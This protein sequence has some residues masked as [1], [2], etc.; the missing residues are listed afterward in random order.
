MIHLSFRSSGYTIF[1][2]LQWLGPWPG[3][4][5]PGVSVPPGHAPYL[6]QDLD[7]VRMRTPDS[8]LSAKD[9]LAKTRSI[10]ETCPAEHYALSKRQSSDT[11]DYSC[12]AT[13]PC[14][15]GACCAKADAAAMALLPVV[16]ANRQ[17]GCARATVMPMR[18]ADDILHLQ[19][20]SVR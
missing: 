16:M 1:F 8:V 10:V 15:N 17:T 9:L 6:E 13:K 4:C 18:N 2:V 11:T 12:C 7:P 19:A 5:M 14:S 20:K 3:F